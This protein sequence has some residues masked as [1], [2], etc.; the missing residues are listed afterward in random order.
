[1]QQKK[2]KRRLFIVICSVVCALIINGF[3]GPGEII[4][5][6]LKKY[7]NA[8]GFKD[9]FAYSYDYS[10]NKFTI[11]TRKPGIW[12]GKGGTGVQLLKEILSQEVKENCGVEFKEIR[13]YFVMCE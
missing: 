2:R 5:N 9:T 11:Y 13:G 8:V 4:E 6:A 3:G 1:M 12:I 7:I 10:E